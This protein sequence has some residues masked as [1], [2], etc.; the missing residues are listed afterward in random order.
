MHM[1]S[2]HALRRNRS[3]LIVVENWL[4]EN[5]YSSSDINGHQI[6]DPWPTA[7]EQ[8]WCGFDLDAVGVINKKLQQE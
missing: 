5:N 6:Y 1:F 2:S 8:G 7:F 4:E 3:E